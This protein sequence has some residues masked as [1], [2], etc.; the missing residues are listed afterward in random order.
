MNMRLREAST[1]LAVIFLL[2]F[3]TITCTADLVPLSIE[4]M[5][6]MADVILIGTIEEVHHCTAS[7]DAIPIMHRQVKVS[8][9]RYLKNPLE[10]ETVTVVARGAT[11]GNTSMWVEDM[12]E[13]EES[14]MVLLFLRDDPWFL[15]ENPQGFYQVVG[16][17]QGKFTVGSDGAVNKPGQVIEDGSS[18]GEIEFK[19][20]ASSPS[21][22]LVFP[23]VVALLSLGVVYVFYLRR[24][25]KLSF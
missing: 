11:V 22:N 20:G 9:D 7:F 18:V 5:T 21:R 2:S 13:F 10:A 25:G 14:E 4:E 16:M 3:Q 23:V 8:V 1:V 6:G 17:C 15:D 19:L 24:L 12:P